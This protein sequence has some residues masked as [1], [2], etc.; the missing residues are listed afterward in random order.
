MKADRPT[1]MM[2]AMF[3]LTSVIAL[4]I[5]P[6]F[7]SEGMQAFEDEDNVAIPLYYIGVILL[8]TAIILVLIKKGYKRL[9][10]GVVVF[11]FFVTISYVLSPF[12]SAL[13]SPP[14][15]EWKEVRGL[16]GVVDVEMLD[17]DGDGRDEI[18]VLKDDGTLVIRSRSR[19]LERQDNVSCISI[20][21][22]R[23]RFNPDALAIIKD[24]EL[25][26]ITMQDGEITL[27][28]S[29]R[30]VTFIQSGIVDDDPGGL[31]LVNDTAVMYID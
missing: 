12:V 17:L 15:E 20:I 3:I 21:N 9:F 13:M 18:A 28:G 27:W 1:I 31:L 23:F 11:A 22:Y 19:V 8:F 2:A 7:V 24:G 26:W 16:E 5:T 29:G 30:A 14:P 6:V 10:H 25:A 4:T